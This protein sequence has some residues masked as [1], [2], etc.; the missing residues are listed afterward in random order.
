MQGSDVNFYF[1]KTFEMS[2]LTDDVLEFVYHRNETTLVTT[3]SIAQSHVT[4]VHTL[5]CKPR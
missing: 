5:F 4:A 2:Y 3:V 1:V